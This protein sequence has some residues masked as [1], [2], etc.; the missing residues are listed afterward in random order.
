MTTT[1]DQSQS[2]RDMTQQDLAVLDAQNVAYIRQV[3]ENGRDVFA[4]HAGDGTR[5]G[6]M[7]TREPA[8]TL[9]S[10]ANY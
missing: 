1:T 8:L 10:N 3:V 6:V 9:A 5:L 7:G 2:F 4:V